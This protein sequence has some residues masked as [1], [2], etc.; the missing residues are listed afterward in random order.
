VADAPVEQLAGGGEELARRWAVSL[1][2]A[3]ALPEMAG[4]PL[5]QLARAA[6]ALCEQLLHALRSDAALAQLLQ[7]PGARERGGEP[8]AAP[9]AWLAR[10]GD[11]AAVVNDV[12][13]LRSVVWAAALDELRDPPARQVAELADRLAFVCSSLAAAALA[14]HVAARA[15]AGDVPAHT[16]ARRAE[17]ILYSSPPSA[18]GG[19]RAVLIDE[20]AEGEGAPARADAT[21]PAGDA[22]EQQSASER[23]ETSPA[24]GRAPAHAQRSGAP[25]AMPRARPWDTPLAAGVADERPGRQE[26]ASWSAVPEPQGGPAALRVTRGPGSPVDER[27]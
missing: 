10:G 5:E 25:R 11:A 15:V 19:R 26:A 21:P 16:R 9:W 6:P 1:L 24:P 14:A 12:E 18:P 27:A 20:G 2:A 4:V 7:S 17:Q 13:A 3:R 8:P 23:T 22:G